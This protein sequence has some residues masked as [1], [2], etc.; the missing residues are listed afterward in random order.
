MYLPAR[1]LPQSGLG[2]FAPQSG[3]ARLAGIPSGR[4]GTIATLN[5]MREYVRASVRL[6]EQIVR[7]KA[8]EIFARAGV[9][10]RKYM[11]ELAAL[12]AFVRD[13]VRY[14]RDPVGVELVQTP[15]V[16]L[17]KMSGDCDDKAT[18]L[19]ALLESTG[20]PAKF[21]AVAFGGNQFSHVLTQAKAGTRWIPAETI[22]QK[23]L[24]WFPPGVTDQ[25]SK[26]I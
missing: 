18:L 4:A 20:H 8:T 11:R 5:H 9:P 24:G 19:A 10:P 14:V 6:P 26:D 12:H 23:P 15:E 16:T 22:I 1:A 17:Q 3:I 7:N 13:R 21:T 2:S 25:Y